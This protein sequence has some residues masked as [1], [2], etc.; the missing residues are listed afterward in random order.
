MTPSELGMKYLLWGI[1]FIMNP[2][3]NIVDILPDFIGCLFIMK[4]LYNVSQIFPHFN[5]A[6][7]YFRNFAIVSA[8]KTVSLPV[9]FIVSASEITWLLLLSFVFGCLEIFYGIMS[10]SS[11]FE[12]LYYSAERG[13]GGAIFSGYEKI[14]T[15]TIFFICFKPLA[16]F[17]PEITSLS[18]GDYGTVTEN[19]VVN[20]AKFRLPLMVAFFVIALAFGIV[21]YVLMRRYL[22]RVLSDD[23]YMS[24][25]CEKYYR[26][27]EDSPQLVERRIVLSS[28]LLFMAAA[29]CSLEIKLDGIN[30]IPHMIGA[31][32]F[33]LAFARVRKIFGKQ[34]RVGIILSSIYTALASLSWGFSFFFTKK[35]IISS[36]TEVGLALGYGE[37]IA[38][39]LGSNEEIT[40]SFTVMCALYAIETLSFIAVVIFAGK[41]L[42]KVLI[43]HGGKPIYELGQC[44]DMRV[45]LRSTALE[46][47]WIGITVAL[48]TLSSILGVCQLVFVTADINLWVPDLALRICWV[49]I[50]VLACDKIKESVK[51]KYIYIKADEKDL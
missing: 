3:I 13:A 43:R 17:L 47:M 18:S 39:Y 31:V 29:I 48:G 11:L 6:S 16:S 37:Q 25:L 35:Y 7:V 26:F 8:A 49:I 27:K 12:G 40:R 24:S 4:G 21:W 5:D 42:S 51:E 19:G 44:H 33:I 1:V 50:F 14:R 2:N 28:V 9:L 10:F 41:I 36:S 23:E 30:Y 46:R 38:A 45:I 15:L 22:K 20:Y 34:A 32:F